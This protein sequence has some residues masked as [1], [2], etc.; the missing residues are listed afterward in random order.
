MPQPVPI[1]TTNWHGRQAQPLRAYTTAEQFRHDDRPKPGRL[2]VTTLLIGLAIFF[3]GHSISIV[4]PSWRNRMAATLGKHT[5]QAI[6]SIIALIGFVLIVR[7]F[8][9]ARLTSPVLYVSPQ[10]LRDVTVGLMILFFPLLL[11]AYLPGRIR[12]TLRN[13]PML[14]ATKLWA[15]AHL[16]ANG[17]VAD[18]VLFGAFL[19]WAAADRISL[20]FRE[21]RPAPALPATR[22]NDAI[23]LVGGLALYIAFI[24]GVHLALIGVP[25]YARWP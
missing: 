7:G 10:W 4:A 21:P 1:K 11:A 3:G 15:A 17:T 9:A 6:Y 18:V 5:W 19:L 14:V 24:G 25:A 20:K 2:T 12:T 13:N 23:A 8:A 22:W 16:L